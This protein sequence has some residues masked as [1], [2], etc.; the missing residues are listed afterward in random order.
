MFDRIDTAFQHPSGPIYFLRGDRCLKFEPGHGVVPRAG[1]VERALRD[2]WPGL[3]APFDRGVDAA[4]HYPKTKS[5]YLFRG[6]RYVRGTLSLLA[7]AAPPTWSDVRRIG[8]DG[9]KTLPVAFRAD[10]DAAFF[11]RDN[12]HAYFFKGGDYVKYHPDDGVVAPG[13][14]R[15]G[16]DGWVGLPER[17]RAGLDGVFDE[18][19]NE[20]TYFFAGREY[21]RWKSGQGVEPRYPR[22]LGLVHG[23]KIVDEGLPGLIAYHGRPSDRGGWPGLSRV[24]A[25]P[26]VGAVSDREASIWLWLADEASFASLQVVSR[27]AAT[28][29]ILPASFPPDLRNALDEIHPRSAPRTIRLT[30]L[31]PATAYQATI[32]L[33]GVELDAVRYRTLQAPSSTGRTTF[34]FGSCAN[35]SE[36]ADVPVLARMSPLEDATVPDFAL[37]AG[38]NC[39]YMNAEGSTSRTGR[40]P[41]DWESLPRMLARQVQARN[42]PQFAALSRSIPHFSTWDDHDFAYNN[43]EGGDASDGWVGREAAARVF[44][45]L[46]P[47]PYRLT[48][49]GQALHYSFRTGPV[50]LFVTDGRF[51]R[52]VVRGRI[53][54]E[55][56]ARWLSESLRA[57][58][59][60]VKIVLSATQVL[61]GLGR[62]DTFAD[63]AE[64]IALLDSGAVSGRVLFLSGDV[65]FAELRRVPAGAGPATR[66]ELTSSPI[67]QA[68][69]GL[70]PTDGNGAQVW[71][72]KRDTFG[73]VRVEVTGSSGGLPRGEIALEARDSKGRILT[74]AVGG[75]RPCRSVWNLETGALT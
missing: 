34:V 22:R 42:H 53:W 30:G 3:P 58:D 7:P 2:E 13:I 17:F 26:L 57:S 38:D 32:S 31:S 54:G 45:A 10:L 19:G 35:I 75:A 73:V 72:A 61:R 62:P 9:W 23:L 67:E 27:P 69:E 59:A 6:G 14:R 71:A 49:D 28:V 40:R 68:N 24:I 21:L 25:G 65:H 74:S 1:G 43:A 16:V 15:L 48:G 70:P 8:V 12:G 47:N 33:G 60:P 36:F 66:V 64:L 18:A 37:M 39:Y 50:D 46:W 63:Q 11:H 5:I 41:R 51:E 29:S 44:R 55:A 52:N 56:Q 4:L 20:R